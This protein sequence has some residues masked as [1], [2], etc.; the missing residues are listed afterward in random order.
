MSLNT[1]HLNIANPVSFSAHRAGWGYAMNHIMKYH[2]PKGILLD[3]FIDITFGYKYKENVASKKIPY[4]KPWIG[5]LHHP[6]TI[7]PWYDTDYKNSIDINSFLNSNEFKISAKYCECLFVLSDYLKTYLVHNFKH[8][9][10]IPIITIKHPTDLSAYKWDY[11]KFKALYS[12]NGLKVISI[13]YFLRNLASLFLL[14]SSKNLDKILLPSHLDLALQNL[15]NELIYKKLDQSIDPSDVK[16]I[17]WQ[18]DD[19]YDKILEQSVVFLDFY[20]TSCNNAIIESLVR[21]C[22]M[23]VNRHPAI[24]EYL[25]K[26][27]PLFYDKLEDTKEL[28]TYDGIQNA[29]E[30]LSKLSYKEYTGDFFAHELISQ[31]SNLGIA[32]KNKQKIGHQHNIRSKLSYKLYSK[33]T[34]FNHR[35]GWQ[36]VTQNIHNYFDNQ[37]NKPQSEKLYLNDFVEHVFKLDNHNQ[38]KDIIIDNLRYRVIRGYSLFSYKNSDLIQINDKYYLWNNNLQT[39]VE[40]PKSQELIKTVEFLSVSTYRNNDWVGFLH[41]PPNMP[42]WFDSNQNFEVIMSKNTD[43]I[44]SLHNCQKLFV[45]SNSLKTYIKNILQQYNLNIPIVVLKH[46]IPPAESTLMFDFDKFVAD[47]KLI[48]IG[49]WMRKMHSFWQINSDLK[50]IWL[51]GHDFAITMLEKEKEN[52]KKYDHLLSKNDIAKIKKSISIGSSININDVEI[53]KVSNHEYDNLLTSS[54]S[55]VNVY[56]TSANNGIIECIRSATPILCNMNPALEEYLGKNYPM[57]FENIPEANRMLKDKDLILET[58]NYLKKNKN[59]TKNLECEVFLEKFDH[60]IKEL[61]KK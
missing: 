43:L 22:P 59:L 51:Y 56:D 39:W 31:L 53:T 52:N 58:H 11:K 28:I 25:G 55:Y 46:P 60:E 15:H 36:W 45:L 48:Q 30:Y 21:S 44:L 27:Y 10:N 2:D 4:K 32:T 29:S 13:G 40:E 61:C 41:N 54:V 9:K 35:F 42:K 6:P 47:P 1:I 20:D 26:E 38:T 8:L 5:F 57:Y 23:I 37:E 50:K 33:T 49:Y 17:D 7:C 14:K 24:E 12:S 19:F 18:N 34:K 3:D 16:I